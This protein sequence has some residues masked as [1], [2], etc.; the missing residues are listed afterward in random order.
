MWSLAILVTNWLI[1]M[2][3]GIYGSYLGILIRIVLSVV[4]YASQAWLGGLCCTVIMSSW[5]YSFMTMKN[6]LPE[7]AY[8]QTRDLIGFL[9]FQIISFPFMLT[10]PE[11]SKNPV[12]VSNVIA[13]CVLAGITIWGGSPSAGIM[14][15]S[16]Y[17]RFARKQKVEV[18][19]TLFSLF[20]LGVA[21]PFMGIIITSSA[22]VY[23]G[24]PM[25]SPVDIIMGLGNGFAGGMDLA[26]LFPK[27]I[28]IRRGSIITALLSWAIQ[29]WL[30]YSIS[31]VFVPAM[32]SFSVGSASN[33]QP[34]YTTARDGAFW[35]T[36]GVN[37][38]GVLTWV[39]CFAPAMP[40]MIAELN[41]SAKGWSESIVLYH[42]LSRIFPPSRVGMQDKHDIY[43]TFD[44][45]T[46]VR[47]GMVLF[48]SQVQRVE[49]GVAVDAV[50]RVAEQGFK[51][52][53]NVK[54]VEVDERAAT[55][56]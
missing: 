51:D 33:S 53:G 26:G 13:F 17:T 24:D 34:L 40:G 27:F 36:Y 35:Y 6:T 38:R 25:W 3:L 8:M 43:G 46:A 39:V 15:Q 9:I 41:T 32:S 48:Q 18:P 5:S 52:N 55:S 49:E 23:G 37:W 4:W 50:A 20:V 44:K 1:G 19:G 12:A 30:I 42:V 7:S 10:R 16:D 11:K 22:T 56:V 45:E 47:K 14:N 2:T 29:P 54:G 31:S 28:N 21:V